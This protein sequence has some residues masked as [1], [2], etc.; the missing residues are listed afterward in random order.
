MSPFHPIHIVHVCKICVSY[1]VERLWWLRQ[2]RQSVM[3]SSPFSVDFL[4]PPQHMNDDIHY[5]RRSCSNLHYP[6]CTYLLSLTI[7]YLHR[8]LI[9]RLLLKISYCFL[10]PERS[11]FFYTLRSETPVHLLKKRGSWYAQAIYVQF[12]AL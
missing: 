3:S 6:G 4:C 2:V 1:S 10:F 7:V 9:R 12:F 8:P 11:W 5:C